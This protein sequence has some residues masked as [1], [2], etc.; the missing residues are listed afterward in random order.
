MKWESILRKIFK[1][2][3]KWKEKKIVYSKRR[4]GMEVMEQGYLDMVE[5]DEHTHFF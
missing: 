4:G 5:G 1:D 2:Q 3:T